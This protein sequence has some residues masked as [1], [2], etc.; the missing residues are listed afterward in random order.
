MT[1][2][3]LKN[4]SSVVLAH[5]FESKDADGMGDNINTDQTT[6]D[7]S[8]HCLPRPICRKT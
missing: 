5:T 6:P 4:V 1:V 3:I 2:I 7:L 8:L